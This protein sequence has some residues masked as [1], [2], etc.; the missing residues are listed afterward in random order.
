MKKTLLALAASIAVSPAYAY[1]IINNERAYLEF[2]GEVKARAFFYENQDNDYT[3]GDSKVGVDA[4]YAATDT[5]NLLGLVEGEVNFD[6][7]ETRDEDDLYFSKYYGGLQHEVLG[8]LTFGKHATSSDDLEGVDYSEAFGG[9]SNLNPVSQHDE[10]L[11]YVYSNELFILSATYGFEAG[12][13]ERDL[14]EL[15]GQYNLGD[16]NIRGGLGTSSTNLVNNQK[17]EFYATTSAEFSRGDYVLGATYY[18][19][20]IDNE[21]DSQRSVKKNALAVAGKVEVVEKLFGYAGYEYIMQDSDTASLDGNLHNVYLGSRYDIVD[22]ANVYAEA[23]YVND[24]T[25]T[26]DDTA[27]NFAVG[28]TIFW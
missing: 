23:N 24:G 7:D 14:M 19:T 9:K 3:F 5:L 20:D 8:A 21:L 11:K 18:Y 28:A 1:E 22:W 6:A 4:R 17:D 12:D 16:L 15:Y 13:N 25:K 2:Y 26:T 10:G 27:V